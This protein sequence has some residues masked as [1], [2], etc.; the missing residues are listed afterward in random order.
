MILLILM[1]YLKFELIKLYHSNELGVKI[2][3]RKTIISL[4]KYEIDQI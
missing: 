4:G 3:K 1:F 2:S